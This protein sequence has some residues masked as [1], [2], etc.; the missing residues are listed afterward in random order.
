MKPKKTK[1]KE[2]KQ[3]TDLG[4]NLVIIL[5]FIFVFLAF[6]FLTIQYSS[7][8]FM[9]DDMVF[10]GYLLLILDFILSKSFFSVVVFVL[11]L[12][13]LK[14]IKSLFFVVAIYNILPFIV[15]FNEMFSL[16]FYEITLV[17]I[18]PLYFVISSAYLIYKRIREKNEEKK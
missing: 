5:G 1:Q 8:F 11:S 17:S 2:E 7:F 16:K 10:S 9:F 12:V 13:Y 6:V 14:K 18:L 4:E 15:S 3:K